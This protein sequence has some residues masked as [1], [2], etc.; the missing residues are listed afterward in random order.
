[1]NSTMG[2]TSVEVGAVPRPPRLSSRRGVP[3]RRLPA[4]VLGALSTAL[5]APAPDLKGATLCLSPLITVSVTVESGLPLRL[6]GLDAQVYDEVKARL[7]AGGVR[8]REEHVCSRANASL[9]L[10]LRVRPTR[11]GSALETQV[12]TYIRDETG[13]GA[14]SWLGGELRWSAVG[15]GKVNPTEAG[16]RAELLADTRAS[17]GQLVNDWK[18]VNR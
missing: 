11:G 13:S 10:S 1:M 15:Y 17:L 18:A 6:T 9:A 14:G 5:A 16:V 3:F 8:Y 4:L 7:G 2:V 12:S